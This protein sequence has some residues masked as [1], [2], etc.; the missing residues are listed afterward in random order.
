MMGF[1]PVIN[2]SGKPALQIRA[3]PVSSTPISRSAAITRLALI[4]TAKRISITISR[5]INQKPLN[6]W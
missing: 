4:E 1:A 6:G 3:H 2:P 5:Q